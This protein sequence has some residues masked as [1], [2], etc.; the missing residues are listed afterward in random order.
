MKAFLTGLPKLIIISLDGNSG[1]IK[2]WF[3]F[4]FSCYLRS[5]SQNDQIKQLHSKLRRP[6]IFK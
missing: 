5:F 3:D 1:E 4:E 2:L 6:I